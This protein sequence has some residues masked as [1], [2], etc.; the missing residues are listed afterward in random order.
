MDA[1]GTE[2]AGGIF[3]N[4][5]RADGRERFLSTGRCWCVVESYH[6]AERPITGT[7]ASPAAYRYI[8]SRRLPISRSRAVL[9]YSARYLR[10]SQHSSWLEARQRLNQQLSH[11]IGT[12]GR[13]IKFGDSGKFRY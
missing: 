3:P 11:P 9:E 12:I 7:A 8:A 13:D 1:Q 6:H 10:A 2:K 5:D 4:A